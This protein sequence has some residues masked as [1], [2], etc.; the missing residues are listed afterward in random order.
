M[1]RL[2]DILVCLADSLRADGA[3]YAPRPLYVFAAAAQFLAAIGRPID[4]DIA[5]A[6]YLAAQLRFVDAKVAALS[7]GLPPNLIPSPNPISAD[8]AINLERIMVRGASEEAIVAAT[9]LYAWYVVAAKSG[10]LDR[11]G[12]LESTAARAAGP[13]SRNAALAGSLVAEMRKLVPTTEPPAR[14]GRRLFSIS[15]D[16]V[17]STDSKTRMMRI[18]RGDKRKIEEL[19]SQIYRAFCG[20][21]RKFYQNSVD[22]YGSGAP[23]DP[24]LFFTVKGIGDEIWILCEADE[25]DIAQ[26]GHRLIDSAMGVAVRSVELFAT[27]N[28]D[29]GTFD[30]DFDYG[31]FESVQSPVKIFID[32]IDH[33]SDLGR[34]RDDALS[35][36][37]PRL[38]ETFHSRMPTQLEVAHVTRRIC[39]SGYEPIGWWRN[40]EARTDYI[41]HE[42]DRFFRATKSALPGTVTIGASM[43]REMG[44]SF[45]PVREAI[46]AVFDRSG[47]A[48]TGG[49]PG[50]SVYARIRTLE[51][52][53]LK[54]IGYAYDTFTLFSPP[55]L[56]GLFLEMASARA[57]GI[58]ALPYEDAA[59]AISPESV[60]ALAALIIE[61]R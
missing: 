30:P 34:E 22:R 52:S 6:S 21:E 41:G 24:A 36:A 59:A 13:I 57:Q 1:P 53:Q 5:S 2:P 35:E 29:L 12:E 55:R 27:E 46:H 26:V 51:A 44:L 7:L 8:E 16:L 48:L 56:N 42:I 28:D 54:G 33:A 9:V 19:N 10:N 37:I 39:L 18:A 58:P 4:D 17:G 15:I 23:I 25:A 47:A 49:G 45:K 43:A 20:I 60:R 32:L 40:E 3:R 50:E 38:L 11:M 14:P 31:D 61:G